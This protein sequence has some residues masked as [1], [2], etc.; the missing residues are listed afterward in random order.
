MEK[1][2]TVYLVVSNS[3]EAIYSTKSQAKNAVETLA[4]FGHDS[5]LKQEKRTVKLA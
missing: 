2:I 1:K 3:V 4:K 5:E